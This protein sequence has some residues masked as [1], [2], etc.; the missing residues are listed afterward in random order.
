MANVSKWIDP[1]DKRFGGV[2]FFSVIR[3]DYLELL[4][5][6]A[7]RNRNEWLRYWRHRKPL[8]RKK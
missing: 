3:I 2:E 1:K 8:R 4:E 7:L 6:D 5:H